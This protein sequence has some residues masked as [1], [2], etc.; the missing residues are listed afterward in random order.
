[1]KSQS[2]S[3]RA[4]ALPQLLAA[5]ALALSGCIIEPNPSPFQSGEENLAPKANSN[6]DE[7]NLLPPYGGHDDD[8]GAFEPV[9]DGELENEGESEEPEC[10]P[11]V[12][13]CTDGSFCRDGW[14]VDAQNCVP[15]CAGESIGVSDGCG[16][17]C[18]PAIGDEYIVSDDPELEAPEFPLDDPLEYDNEI[19][20]AE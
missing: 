7:Q 12:G 20:E 15:K 6:Y 10:G 3:I 11:E 1:M 19:P 17:I 8:D 5:C 2:Q 16:G 18:S 4:I 14:C 13:D 9:P